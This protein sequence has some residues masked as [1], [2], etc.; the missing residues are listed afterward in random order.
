MKRIKSLLVLTLF[1][2]VILTS[3]AT[4]EEPVKGVESSV[5]ETGDVKAVKITANNCN[6]TQG[7]DPTSKVLQ[8]ANK[9]ANLNVISKV[10]EDWFCVKL[11]NNQIGFVPQQQ[12]T[13]ILPNNAIN[14]GNVGQTPVASKVPTPG[15]TTEKTPRNQTPRGTNQMYSPQT[16][17][18]VNNREAIPE[19]T[20]GNYDNTVANDN[21]EDENT[22]TNKNISNEEQQLINLI[23]ESRKQNGLKALKADN[24]LSEIARIKSKDMIDNNYFSHNSPTYGN[25]F[26]MLKNFGIQYLSAAENIAGNNSVQEAHEALMNSPGHR[27]NILN[28]EVTHVG[29]GIQK[30]SKY[31]YMFTEL[32]IKK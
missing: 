1:T 31:G 24:Q 16:R 10:N 14:K 32:F 28:P 5:N 12:C 7:C 29:V 19:D 13:P 21:A 8:T 2:T 15:T 30:G 9:D 11:P 26:D 25:P 20:R 27:K 4:N 23:N 18:G 17:T 3:C 6:V 22:T